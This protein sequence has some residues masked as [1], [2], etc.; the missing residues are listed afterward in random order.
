MRA[1]TALTACVGISAYPE[2]VLAPGERP[3]KHL[4]NGARH[5]S[6]LFSQM[7]PD[8]GSRHLLALDGDATL[9]HL[10]DTIVAQTGP[11][12]IFILYLAGHGRAGQGAFEFLFFGEEAAVA[13]GT[14]ADVDA[15]LST[16][17]ATNT[18]LL[19]D[20]CHSGQYAVESAF[21]RGTTSGRTRLGI[22][23]SMAGQKSWE[24]DHFERSLFADALAKAITDDASVAGRA[25][26]VSGSFFRDVAE[27]VANHAFGFKGSAAQEPMIFGAASDVLELVTTASQASRRGSLTTYQTLRRRTRQIGVA[28]MGAAAVA[29]VSTS[30]AT[31]RPAIGPSGFVELR[32]GP[33][34]LSP[35]NVGPWARRV[36]ADVAR[37]DLR[38]DELQAE[39][40]DEQGLHAWPGLG[41][42]DV[43]RWADVFVEVYLAP[44][45]AARW[46]V[47]LGFADAVDRLTVPGHG[48]PAVPAAPLPSATELAAEA[49]LLQP[50]R[51]PPDVWRIQWGNKVTSGTCAGKAPNGAPSDM[52]DF[53]LHLSEPIE[54][55]DWLRGLSATAREDERV[56][57]AQ[58]ADLV[59]MFTT[60]SLV[61]DE[62]YRRTLGAPGPLT[63]DRVVAGL[64]ESPSGMEVHALADVAAAIVARR[65]ALSLPAVTPDERSAISGLMV[66]CAD[67]AVHVLA[68]LGD[69]GAPEKVIA[70]AHARPKQDQGRV[71]LAEL[72]EYGTLPDAEV[73]RVLDGSGFSGDAEARRYAFVSSREWLG[74]IAASR[75]LPG[76]V[77]RKLVDYAEARRRAGDGREE[78]EALRLVLGNSAV[79]QSQLGAAV[80]S[81]VANGGDAGPLPP[82]DW[83]VEVAGLLARAGVPLS[84][85]QRR[86]LD[87][88]LD[89]VEPKVSYTDEDKGKSMDASQLVAG[90]TLSDLVAVYRG[91]IAGK[92]PRDASKR[93][94]IRG[95]LET[96][97]ADGI[98]FGVEPAKLA[99]PTTAAAVLW[100]REASDG[101]DASFL[102]HRLECCA[103]DR[104]DRRAHAD[105]AVAVLLRMPTR[106]RN[107]VIDGVREQ[108]RNEQEPE[109]K[110]ALADVIV[111]TLVRYD[112]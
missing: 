7:W 54:Y 50:E 75:A 5:L 38:D 15:L 66:G 102:H 59:R 78:R 19:L 61:S 2:A 62:Q 90:L 33:K 70:W 104:A 82:S 12:D 67:V 29:C 34:W 71:V 81:L 49:R 52:L 110:L 89:G 45:A 42:A 72:A 97:L 63:A 57:F 22:A 77:V 27:G 79:A 74:E 73:E 105:V 100:E 16:A 4:A 36:E 99:D 95:F 37:S 41:A 88:I 20:A 43:R 31:W 39:L 53:Y 94:A 83:D 18:L 68:A 93:P 30:L 64:N 92:V 23:S 107:Q 76:S 28:A 8:E 25:K 17:P 9:A 106:R 40:L 13:R 44:D 24:D 112:R 85:T 35:M 26:V 56:G 48:F 108:W 65:R 103:T 101:V 14:A 87:E 69:E 32:A 47:R 109:V 11:F 6:R 58:V 46:R 1:G 51:P 21:F 10:R 91:V 84:T 55:R 3:L 96:A 86:V 98:R 80:A 111:R 60:A